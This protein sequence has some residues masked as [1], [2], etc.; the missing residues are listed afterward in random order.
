MIRKAAVAAMA[1]A[2]AIAIAGCGLGAG[3]GTSNVTLTVT[4]GFGSQQVARISERGVPGSE[5]VMR[6]LE[7]HFRVRTRYGGG[8]VQSI[9]GTAGAPAHGPLG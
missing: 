8:F 3:P 6:M 9:N 4:R 2:S 7:R 5:T 1:V